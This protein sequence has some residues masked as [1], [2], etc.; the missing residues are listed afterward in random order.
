MRVRL[1]H[2]SSDILFKLIDW[3]GLNA[4]RPRYGHPEHLKASP[5][6]H[7]P[8]PPTFL[9]SIVKS[10]S[11]N[12]SSENLMTCCCLA[13]LD[14]IS[15]SSISLSPHEQSLQ[16]FLLLCLDLPHWIIVIVSSSVSAIKSSSS[17]ESPVSGSSK[18]SK[19][20][21]LELFA[22]SSLSRSSSSSSRSE[23]VS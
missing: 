8:Q 21:V 16:A 23:S 3:P 7:E 18:S 13:L 6:A 22:E 15:C 17:I 5:R 2:K 19:N 14:S 12:S 4:G 10:I 9:P 1:L 20:L 11:V